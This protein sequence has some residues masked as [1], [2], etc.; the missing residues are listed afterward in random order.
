M[1]L[2][3]FQCKAVKKGYLL[4]QISPSPLTSSL[5]PPLCSS[6]EFH[7]IQGTLLPPNV[8]VHWYRTCWSGGMRAGGGGGGGGG[9]AFALRK[10][11]CLVKL[12]HSDSLPEYTQIREEATGEKRKGDQ[13][14]LR[15]GQKAALI[16]L[17]PALI[18]LRLIGLHRK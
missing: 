3:P 7:G 1:L 16:Q 5:P 2:H 15:E 12:L 9:Y 4:S 10:S 8:A 11:R 17:I 6:S 13:R 18:Q 14:V